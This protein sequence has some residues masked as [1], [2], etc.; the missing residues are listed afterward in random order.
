[1]RGGWCAEPVT[2]G[3][4]VFAVLLTEDSIGVCLFLLVRAT[5]ALRG[6]VLTG[7]FLAVDPL[8]LRNVR[9]EADCG[10]VLRT[11][12]LRRDLTEM[13]CLYLRANGG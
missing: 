9:L 11:A 5:D 10:R 6:S 4:Y 2:L 8:V 12:L 13:R 3:L 7:V 1:M